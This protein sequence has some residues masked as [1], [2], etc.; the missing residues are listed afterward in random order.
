LASVL[1][2][3]NDLVAP[4]TIEYNLG[5]EHQL[6]YGFAVAATYVGSRGVKLYANQQYNYFDSTTGER[7]NP[8]RGAVNARGNF[9]ASNY[10]GLEV[11]ARRNF[12]HGFAIFASYVYS[13][14]LDNGSEVFAA[15]SSPTSYSADLAPGGR[16]FDW[17][18]S[19]YDHRHYGAINYVWSPAGFHAD[20]HGTDLLLSALTRHWTISGGSH[21]QSGA[22]STVNFLGLDSNGDGS[23]ANDRPFLSNRSAPMSTVGIDGGYLDPSLAGT[24]F[25]LAALNNNQLNVVD[26]NKVRWLIPITN[27]YDPRE[28]GRN[29]FLN[30]GA[31]YN[32][33][34]LEKAIPTGFL[35]LDRG[36][37]IL[38]C[39][40]QNVA[41]HNNVGLLDV[42]LLDVGTPFFMNT[43]QAREANNRAVRFWAKFVF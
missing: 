2:V 15:D 10:N 42:N 37:F 32:D 25:D 19:A 7:L 31:L 6:P 40:A 22:Y 14:A 16:R 26:P 11:G 28:I 33:V 8:D 35:H 23:T 13:K 12:T 39:E 5:V 3:T 17:A 43:S 21:F 9:A 18:N 29:S 36:S 34:A 38:R 1:S 30:P 4:Y 41:N 20:S 27:G 24:Y